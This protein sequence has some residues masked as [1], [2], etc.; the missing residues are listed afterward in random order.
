M[1]GQAALTAVAGPPPACS[2]RASSE[3]LPYGPAW[4][5]CGAPPGSA[6]AGAGATA[7][8]TDA[9]S[10][11]TL[12]VFLLTFTTGL[13]SFLRDRAWLVLVGQGLAKPHAPGR[14]AV[15]RIG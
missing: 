15:M 1:P 10:S 3:A 8:P 13:P 2:H 11:S 9:A 14:R 6:A 4:P 12:S 7:D 5:A